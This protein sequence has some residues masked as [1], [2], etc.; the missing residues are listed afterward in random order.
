MF[1]FMPALNNTKS[2]TPDWTRDQVLAELAKAGWSLRRLALHHNVRPSTQQQVL[3][4]PYPRGE[5]RVAEA[6][7]L[8][9]WQIWP[10]RYDDNGEPNRPMGR[11]SFVPRV[12]PNLQ[13]N[14][15]TARKGVNVKRAR[16]A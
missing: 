12:I 4:R 2:T 1:T 3:Y 8:N 6:L 9:A 13:R 7:A 14:R 11:P 15:S 10:S 5:Q 16:G